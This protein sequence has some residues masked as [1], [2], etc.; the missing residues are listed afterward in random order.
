MR[1]G[2]LTLWIR[3]GDTIWRLCHYLVRWSCWLC[4]DNAWFVSLHDALMC[5]W[6]YS[7]SCWCGWVLVCSCRCWYVF[8]CSGTGKFCKLLSCLS[9]ASLKIS[10]PFY[11]LMYCTGYWC[12]YYLCCVHHILIR[13]CAMSGLKVCLCRCFV[14]ACW[15]YVEFPRSIVLIGWS[16]IPCINGPC[17]QACLCFWWFEDSCATTGRGKGYFVKVMRALQNVVYWQLG[18]DF[19][20]Y[21]AYLMC[22]VPV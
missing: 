4:R 14:S 13:H 17:Y 2:A 10:V 22:L 18:F 8:F 20:M 19:E 12:C 9:M 1:V 3:Y 5:M 6:W 21:R 16:E 7:C 15:W 11:Y